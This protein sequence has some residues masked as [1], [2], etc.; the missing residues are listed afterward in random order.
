MAVESTYSRTGNTSSCRIEPVARL[1]LKTSLTIFTASSTLGR[2]LFAT[3]AVSQVD[4]LTV[5]DLAHIGHRQTVSRVF[6]V[7]CRACETVSGC[8]VGTLE[9][10]CVTRQT[11]LGLVI[12]VLACFAPDRV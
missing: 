7:T 8:V 4:V 9:T 6:E 12:V 3:V 10:S 11:L 5:E 2:A 1:A